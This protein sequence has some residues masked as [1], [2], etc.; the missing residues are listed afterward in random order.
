MMAA[1]S[2][3][4]NGHHVT[5]I[6]QNEKLGKKLFITGKGRCNFTNASSMEEHQKN[7]VSNP[8]F[9]FRAYASFTNKDIMNLLEEEGVP[10]KV[11]RG[12]R[13][14]PE[15]DKSSDVTKALT[16]RLNRNGVKI[17]LNSRVDHINVVDS[18]V[19]GVTLEKGEVLDCDAVVIATGGV[20][21]PSTGSTGDGYQFAYDNGMNITE[22][23][24]ALVPFIVSESWVKQL[25]GLN[26]RNV[27]VVIK[28]DKKVLYTDFGELTFMSYGVS[29]PTVLSASSIVGKIL[30]VTL[31]IDLKPALDEKK[32]DDRMLREF[33]AHQNLTIHSVMG[34][35]L[36]AKLIPVVLD[37]AGIAHDKKVHDITKEER[38]KL[39]LQMKDLELTLIKLRPFDEAIVTQGGVSVKDIN[40]STMESKMV[41]GMYF[42]GEVMDVDALTGGYNLQI[43]WST[44]Y[45]AGQSIE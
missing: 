32:L 28:N 17:R 12:N 36:P 13:V 3:S 38:R 15:S 21:Y 44:G 19:T 7:V 16:Q 4:S 8:K 9:L 23:R 22:L 18:V 14:F 35:L 6:E 42:A 24:A 27:G 5:L 26:L 33:T 39:V 40:P 37:L 34:Q 41:K 20:S 30:P 25:A 45:L 11:E 31:K 10:V 29:G 1:I 43:A 2:A